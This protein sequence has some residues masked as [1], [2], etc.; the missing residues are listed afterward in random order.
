MN[1][2]SGWWGVLVLVTSVLMAWWWAT[3][4]APRPLDTP[5]ERPSAERAGQIL[6]R[7]LEGVGPHPVGT[8]AA[9]E[10]EARLRRELQAIGLHPEVRSETLCLRG[11]CVRIRN[12]EAVLEGRDPLLPAILVSSHYDS[13]RA[14]PGYGDDGAGVAAAIEIARATLHGEPLDRDV[15]FLFN[16]G[17]EDGLWGARAFVARSPHRDRI[18]AVINLEA[19]G[20]G[21]PSY[22]FEMSGNTWPLAQAWGASAARPSGSSLYTAIYEMLPNNTDLTVYREA[23]YRGANFA[24]LRGGQHYHTPL[25]DREHLDHGSVQHHA[26]QGFDLLRELAAADRPAG[27]GDAVFFDVLGLVVMSWPQGWNPVW[28]GGLGLTGLALVGLTVFRRRRHLPALAGGILVVLLSVPIAIGLA[29][30]LE[31]TLLAAGATWRTQPWLFRGAIWCLSLAVFLGLGSLGRRLGEHGPRVGVVLWQLGLAT[32]LGVA[33]PGG[34]YLGVLPAL[35]AV[36]ALA[37][38]LVLY[39]SPGRRLV[40]L[41][42]AAAS[43]VLWMRLALGFEAALGPGGAVVAA[44]LALALLPAIPVLGDKHRLSTGPGLAISAGVGALGLLLGV[45]TLAL[46][47]TSIDRP[48]GIEGRYAAGAWSL[49]NRTF[50]AGGPLPTGFSPRV[51]DP[52]GEMAVRSREKGLLIVPREGVDELTIEVRGRRITAVDGEPVDATERIHWTGAAPG[53]LLLEL[54]G[55]GRARMA[56]TEHWQADTTLPEGF[57]PIHTGLRARETTQVRISE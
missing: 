10:V 30:G 41:V 53:G 37:A 23:G 56:V 33:L 14:G 5:L 4:P 44:P 35:F 19:R 34:A 11:R 16:E 1:H 57:V 26:D 12:V 20:T 48:Y 43:S 18:D 8:P 7:L 50:P 27:P 46:P 15:V 28:L 40:E 36:I 47:D 52:P 24:F 54:S 17:E 3:A 55:H 21:G 42:C 39:D 38:G 25:D 49:K 9:R 51:P 6:H 13:V 31:A 29:V 22:L 45:A 2:R 32:V